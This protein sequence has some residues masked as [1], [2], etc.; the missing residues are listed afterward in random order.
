MKKKLCALIFLIIATSCLSASNIHAFDFDV[1]KEQVDKKLNEPK[2][3][4]TSADNLKLGWLFYIFKNDTTKAITHLERSIE[5]DARTYEAHLLLGIINR[6]L[7]NTEKAFD[8]WFSCLDF[9]RLE[10]NYVI[11]EIIGLDLSYGNVQKLIKKLEGIIESPGHILLK[12]KARWYLAYLYRK[13]SNLTK[14]RQAYKK[15]G[16]ID[17][18]MIIGPFDNK[19]KMALKEPYLPESEI[20]FDKSYTGKVKKIC[21][22]ELNYLEY[23]Q[24]VNLNSVLYPQSWAAAYGLTYIYSPADKD[25]IFWV[26]SDDAIKVWLNDFLIF[27]NEN[28][29]SF[30][31]DQYAIHVKLNKGWNKVLVKVC[32][33][34]GSWGF[35][36]RVTDSGARPLTGLK[37]SREIKPYSK[38]DP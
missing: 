14:S 2:D 23:D 19:E 20:D 35:G 7:G 27:K 36:L 30:I 6:E 10:N 29:Q 22:R 18:W 24:T 15:I 17:K 32:E 26:G 12:P 1:N 33:G 31:T 37:Y 4:R 5:L 25:V 16:F 13:I 9:D 21:W 34:I 38:I 28:Y 8:F 11:S 3:S